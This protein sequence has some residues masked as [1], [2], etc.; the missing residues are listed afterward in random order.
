MGCNSITLNGI[1]SFCETS[2]GGI[3]EVYGIPS[4]AISGVTVATAATIVESSSC[5]TNF[6]YSTTAHSISDWV[7]YKF[8]KDS[9]SLNK[10]YAYD[11]ATGYAAYESELTM[12]FTRM[13]AAK[14]AELVALAMGGAKFIVK[15]ANG[16]YWY[17]GMDN[18]V[19][20][21]QLTGQTGQAKTD[22]NYYQVVVKDTAK[23]LPYEVEPGVAQAIAAAID[24]A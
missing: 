7:L 13:D 15:D 1:N 5:V 23:Q 8:R 11:D 22:G 12:L 17:L 14:R 4:D 10:S 6:G 18:D 16:H 24:A 21:D 9:S 20:V 3:V 2:I 19:V